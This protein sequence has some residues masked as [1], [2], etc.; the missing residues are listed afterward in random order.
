MCDFEGV[1]NNGDTF[2]FRVINNQPGKSFRNEK[3]GNKREGAALRDARAQLENGAIN[4]VCLDYTFLGV[5][6]VVK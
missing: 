2:V 5:V 4:A 6:G 3:E 1:L